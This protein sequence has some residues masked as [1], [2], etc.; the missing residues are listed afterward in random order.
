MC[1]LFFL[2]VSDPDAVLRASTAFFVELTRFNAATQFVFVHKKHS[3]WVLIVLCDE[4][5]ENIPIKR[6]DKKSQ[7]R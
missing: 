1:G 6:F 7:S 3:F 4:E 5:K 2:A